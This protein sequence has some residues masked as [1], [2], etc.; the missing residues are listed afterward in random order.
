[1]RTATVGKEAAV[2]GPVDCQMLVDPSFER[3]IGSFPPPAVDVALDVQRCEH[4]NH[5]H[6]NHLG[7]E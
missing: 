1:M 5:H 2:L 3:R 4:E 6:L 7:A